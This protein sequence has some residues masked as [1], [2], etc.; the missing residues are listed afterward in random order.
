MPGKACNGQCHGNRGVLLCG[1]PAA[2]QLC[3]QQS[4]RPLK[5]TVAGRALHVILCP[6]QCHFIA[7]ALVVFISTG[8]SGGNMLIK[9]G[10]ERGL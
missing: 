6:G 5:I 3:P 9:V 2:A 1:P 10:T 8:I 7:A 4:A